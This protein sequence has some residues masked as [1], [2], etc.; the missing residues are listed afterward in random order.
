DPHALMLDVSKGKPLWDT[1]RGKVLRVDEKEHKVYLDRGSEHGVKPGLTFNVFG[2]TFDNRADGPLKGTVEVLRV[3]DGK[4]SVARAPQRYD[5]P[6]QEISLNDPT[7]GKVLREGSN[8]IKEGDLLFN[9]AG[10]AHVAGAGVIDWPGNG[11]A[12]PAA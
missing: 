3:L 9:L 2:A 5:I 4:T 1:P 11:G 8:A 12:R 6:A 10:G 7:Q